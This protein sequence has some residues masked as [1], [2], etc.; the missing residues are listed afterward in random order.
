ML[1]PVELREE[2]VDLGLEARKPRILRQTLSAP[3][4]GFS[5]RSS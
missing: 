4:T 1:A 3:M 5:V 2:A